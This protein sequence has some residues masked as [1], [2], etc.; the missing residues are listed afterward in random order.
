MIFNPDQTENRNEQSMTLGLLNWSREQ[1]WPHPR[2]HTLRIRSP[3]NQLISLYKQDIINMSAEFSDI[4]EVP[5]GYFTQSAFEHNM[6]KIDPASI[7]SQERRRKRRM[8]SYA[9]TNQHKL[10]TQN[11]KLKRWVKKG[12]ILPMDYE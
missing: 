12:K 10:K 2:M 1:K 9:V 7:S 11:I 8:M 3:Q 6:I 5:E 4:S